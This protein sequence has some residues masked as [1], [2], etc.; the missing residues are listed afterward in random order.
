MS[1]PEPR[2]VRRFTAWKLP[3]ISLFASMFAIIVLLLYLWGSSGDVKADGVA[4]CEASWEGRTDAD[5]DGNP[6]AQPNDFAGGE[7]VDRIVLRSRV[8]RRDINDSSEVA[9]RDRAAIKTAVAILKSR[10]GSRESDSR[11]VLNLDA[12]EAIRAIHGHP[13]PHRLKP[14]QPED[15]G[16]GDQSI[17]LWDSCVHG[18][19][20]NLRDGPLFLLWHRA[21]VRAFEISVNSLLAAHPE[22]HVLAREGVG[23]P[24]WNW[25]ELRQF[26]N[27][28][29]CRDAV[30]SELDCPIKESE[31]HLD[32]DTDRGHPN[33]LYVDFRAAA[34]RTGTPL[35]TPVR[36]ILPIDMTHSDFVRFN[37]ELESTWHDGIHTAVG[38]TGFSPGGK[39]TGWMFKPHSAVFDPA[40]WVHHSYVDQLLVAWVAAVTGRGAEVANDLNQQAGIGSALEKA[41][42]LKRARFPVVCGDRVVWYQPPFLDV[43][44]TV[45]GEVDPSIRLG[46]LYDRVVLPSPPSQPPPDVS[47]LIG[48]IDKSAVVHLGVMSGDS[49]WQRRFASRDGQLTVVGS[50]AR[51]SILLADVRIGKQTQRRLRESWKSLSKLQREK[52]RRRAVVLSLDRTRLLETPKGSGVYVVAGRACWD[53][54]RCSSVPW[55]YLSTI[56]NFATPIRGSD[57]NGNHHQSDS[58]VDVTEPIF[59]V[60]AAAAGGTSGPRSN[61]EIAIFPARG[62]PDGVLV[63][64]ED[65]PGL[66]FDSMTV[67]LRYDGDVKSSVRSHAH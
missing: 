35:W 65:R 19:S 30:P 24:Y 38:G 51:F 43:A 36:G 56:S 16:T 10:D 11:R 66:Q 26:P 63:A 7:V 34:T 46:Y 58:L 39:G 50:G 48:A 9:V 62:S 32:E 5:N 52:L 33:P 59:D 8:V 20:N 18:I 29:R 23:I 6:D 25:V 27:A 45:V 22:T 37:L 3:W 2:S 61:I 55:R 41:W 21:Y 31:L 44:P 13:S 49:S 15:D 60:L 17:R 54:M 57:N 14:E 47:K 12:Y 53:S 28:L 64:V 40:F 42:I 1:S 67:S 4:V